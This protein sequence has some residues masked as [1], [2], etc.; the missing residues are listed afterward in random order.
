MGRISSSVVEEEKCPKGFKFKDFRP[1]VAT[2]GQRASQVYL[3][4]VRCYKM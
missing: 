1:K 3:L 4:D 2:L